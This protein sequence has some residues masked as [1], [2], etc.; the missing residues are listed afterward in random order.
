MAA[1]R[2][3]PSEQRLLNRFAADAVPSVFRG[4]DG[5]IVEADKAN[6]HL[7]GS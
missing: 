1:A 3:R 4:E 2:Q 6:L 7:R 5:Q